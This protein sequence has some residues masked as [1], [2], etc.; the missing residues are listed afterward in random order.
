MILNS[1]FFSYNNVIYEQ[2]FETPMGSPLSSIVT[3][4]VMCDLEGRT[5]ETL[6]IPLP[7]YVDDIAKEVLVCLINQVLNIFNSFHTR[8]LFTLKLGGDKLNYLNVTIH[9]KTI[10]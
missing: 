7:F 5:L 4:L 8:L 10:L 2:N 6:G 1:T 9:K 3:D